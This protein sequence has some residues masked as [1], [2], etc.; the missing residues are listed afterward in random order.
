[1]DW[2]FKSGDLFLPKQV[3]DF[4]EYQYV[5][6]KTSALYISNWTLV[7]FFSGVLAAYLLA[8]YLLATRTRYSILYILIV[9]LLFHIVWELWQIYGKNTLIWTRRGQ[10][11]V[12]VDTVAFMVGAVAYIQTQK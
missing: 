4:L 10:V 1:M 2:K 7:H 6:T 5:G 8:A 11:D 3:R 9:A 12:F